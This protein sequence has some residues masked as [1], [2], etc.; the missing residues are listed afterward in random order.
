MRTYKFRGKDSNGIWR[1]G[2]LL[3]RDIDTGRVYIR[4]MS[5]ENVPPRYTDYQ[6]DPKSVGQCINIED[7]N[8]VIVYENDIVAVR[9]LDWEIDRP[10]IIGVITYSG[11][12][13]ALKVNGSYNHLW[14]NAEVIE[15]VGNGF[16][17]LELIKK[18]VA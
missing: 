6:V 2:H 11:S 10:S 16:D 14:V 5:I 18:E 17:T 9:D 3:T 13:F 15:V 4:E 1:Y 7:T 8:E 12:G